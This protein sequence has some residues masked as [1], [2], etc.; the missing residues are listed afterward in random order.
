MPEA[1]GHLPSWTS[2]D[3]L[4]SLSGLD[5]LA[6]ETTKEGDYRTVKGVN[7]LCNVW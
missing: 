7:A 1:K 2:Q 6:K 4:S 3:L 5:S